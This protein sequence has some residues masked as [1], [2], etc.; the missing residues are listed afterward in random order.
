MIYRVDW[1]SAKTMI[2]CGGILTWLGVVFISPVVAWLINVI[3]WLLIVFGL[4]VV[5]LGI[6]SWAW[7]TGRRD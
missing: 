3:G 1:N 6:G 5:A 2:G 4:L 7:G